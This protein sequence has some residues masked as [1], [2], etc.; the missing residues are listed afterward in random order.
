MKRASALYYVSKEDPPLLIS[1]GGKDHTV[2][3]DQS[4]A[5]DQAYQAAGLLSTLPLVR[6][7]GHG[8]KDFFSPANK[9]QILNFLKQ[10][11]DLRS[12]REERNRDLSKDKLFKAAKKKIQTT[13]IGALSTLESSFGFLWGFDVAEEDKTVEKG[14]SKET[15]IEK[16]EVERKEKGRDRDKKGRK[17]RMK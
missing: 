9:T 7:S 13:M 1:H 12:T 2:L 6:G 3:M 16:K 5:I 11:L 15:E 17:R 8:G 14:S 10:S 4:E